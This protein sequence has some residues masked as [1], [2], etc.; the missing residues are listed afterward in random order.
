MDVPFVSKSEN[1]MAKRWIDYIL[2]HPDE[3][4]C[5][6]R[7]SRNPNIEWQDVKAHP[8]CPWDYNSL[9]MNPNMSWKIITENLNAIPWCMRALSAHTDLDFDFVLA[10]PQLD[11]NWGEI[12]RNPRVTWEIYKNNKH[13]YNQDKKKVLIPWSLGGLSVNPNITMDIIEANPRLNWSFKMLPYNPNLTLD[14]IERHI[15]KPWDF[16]ALSIQKVITIEFVNKYLHLPWSERLGKNPNITIDI[17]RKNRH[18]N[19]VEICMANNPNITIDIIKAN[20]DLFRVEFYERRYPAEFEKDFTLEDY[21]SSNENI[22][23]LLWH[24]VSQCPDITWEIVEQNPTL[25]NYVSLSANPMN[26]P[27]RKRQQARCQVFKE[28]LIDRVFHPD[29]IQSKILRFGYDEVTQHI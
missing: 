7:I 6:Y 26:E 5:W 10:N 14:F 12:S 21:L 27:T 22:R 19:W 1:K 28:E 23:R 18:I 29:Y 4:W 24:R 20:P 11:W 25:W 9:S 3:R 13:R 17:I 8:K 15:D 2:A 16:D